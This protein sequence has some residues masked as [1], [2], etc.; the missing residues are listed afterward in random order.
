MNYSNIVT[1][2]STILIALIFLGGVFINL[3]IKTSKEELGELYQTID[4]LKLE[5][6]RQK[7][8][9]ATLTSPVNI[10][11]YI[12]KYD[13]KPVKLRNIENIYIK[14]D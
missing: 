10:V 2:I 6:K 5:I 7:I 8:E 3:D 9:M 4:R 12:E 14:K 11:R 13:L 1:V